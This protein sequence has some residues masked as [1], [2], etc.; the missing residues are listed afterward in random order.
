MLS[1][2]GYA[3]RAALID[4]I[5]PANIRNKEALPLGAYAQPMPENEALN[6][7]KKSLRKTR[8]SSR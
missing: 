6:K 4:A 5:V 3:S 8:C 7:L 2:L 1:V